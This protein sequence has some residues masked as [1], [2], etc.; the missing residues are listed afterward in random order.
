M[1]KRELKTVLRPL[2]FEIGEETINDIVEMADV[3]GDGVIEYEQ[4]KYAALN[5]P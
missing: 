2:Y 1:S 5:S 3:K 4:F